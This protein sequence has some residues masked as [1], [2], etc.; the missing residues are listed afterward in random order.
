MAILTMIVR[1]IAHRKINCLLALVGVAAAVGL[2]V[3]VLAFLELHDR[4]TEESVVAEAEKTRENMSQLSDD[5]RRSM[6]RLGYNAVLLPT[7]QSLGDWYADDFAEKTMPDELGAQ[8]ATTKGLVD[9]FLPLLRTKYV[10][11]ENRWTV[12]VVGIGTERILDTSVCD[13]R[14]LREP[15]KRGTCRVGFELSQGLKLVAGQTVSLGGHELRITEVLEEGGTKD[16]IT[17]WVDLSEAQEM[18]DQPGRINELLIVE[19]AR[20]WGHLSEVKRRVADVMPMVQVVEFASETLSRA[21]ARVKIADQAAASIQ[22]ERSKQELLRAERAKALMLLLPLGA[23]VCAGWIGLLMYT[24]VR[25]RIAET[26]I[27]MAIGFPLAT[28]RNLF[29]GKAVILGLVGGFCGFVAGVASS[30]MLTGA[31]SWLSLVTVELIGRYLLFSLGIGLLAGL[32]GS[33]LPVR[34]ATALDPVATLGRE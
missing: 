3:G 27:L 16:D 8:L 32:M 20:V 26:G 2:L 34:A 6:Q 19:H 22:H 9:R 18:F 10:W 13:D 24:N 29:L 4:Q 1:E 31:D 28:V 14:P 15:V 25:E 30:L 17:I 23:V 5:V 21:H 12:L 11:P 33:Y 7:D